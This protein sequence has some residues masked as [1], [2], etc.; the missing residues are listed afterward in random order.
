MMD[1]TKEACLSFSLLADGDLSRALS[2]DLTVDD[3]SAAV[4]GSGQEEAS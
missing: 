3:D 2:S 1:I 4:F